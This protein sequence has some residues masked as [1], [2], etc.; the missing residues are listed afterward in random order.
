MQMKDDRMRGGHHGG[1]LRY[2]LLLYL[3]SYQPDYP[4]SSCNHRYKK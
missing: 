1:M 3:P 4:E 2:T